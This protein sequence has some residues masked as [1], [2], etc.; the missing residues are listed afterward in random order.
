MFIFNNKKKVEQTMETVGVSKQEQAYENIKNAIITNELSANAV[1]M[2]RE[3]CTKLQISRTPIRNA[4]I[5]LEKE[6]FV[7]SIPNK[8]MFVS[9]IRLKDVVEIY[10]FREALD[11]LALRL[12]AKLLDGK[13][14][15]ELIEDVQLQ[16]EAFKVAKDTDLWEDYFIIDQKF[17]KLYVDKCNNS[18]IINTYRIFADQILRFSLSTFGDEK[19]ASMSIKE[20]ND[21]ALAV[22]NDDIKRAE[23]M[24]AEHMVSIKNYFIESS[25]KSGRY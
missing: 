22:A 1:L 25:I 12:S 20:H 11:P 24:L 10:E 21:V 7:E 14:G 6:G 13:L 15:K 3:L 8:G 18:R 16:Q 4:L 2:E 5:R 23:E 9:E 17:H 19:R